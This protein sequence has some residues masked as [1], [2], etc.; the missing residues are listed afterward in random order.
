MID[1]RTKNFNESLPIRKDFISRI[2][3]MTIYSFWGDWRKC[4]DCGEWVQST[5]SKKP[6]SIEMICFKCYRQNN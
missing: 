5:I 3:D 6:G 2:T 4:P 1:E